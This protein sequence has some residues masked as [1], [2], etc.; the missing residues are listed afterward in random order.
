[1]L[2]ES[3]KG[4]TATI[5]AVDVVALPVQ[6]QLDQLPHIGVVV[7]DEDP[8]HEN[9]GIVLHRP[10]PGRE[11]LGPWGCGYA[12]PPANNPSVPSSRAPRRPH[13]ALRLLK[14]HPA[15]AE[16]LMQPALVPVFDRGRRP[17]LE[18]EVASRC[19]MATE[20]KR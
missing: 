13:L 9:S 1:M 12:V 18:P 6:G 2:R 11:R 17:V 3:L 8:E 15:C 4:G 20:P 19:G 7:H 14:R 16:L 5:D 10:L